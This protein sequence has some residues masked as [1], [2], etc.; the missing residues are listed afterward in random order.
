MSSETSPQGPQTW[1]E[2]YERITEE[3]RRL[4]GTVRDDASARSFVEQAVRLVKAGATATAEFYTGEFYSRF[5]QA[6][7]DE[8]NA[9]QASVERESADIKSASEAASEDINPRLQ[10]ARVSGD[11]DAEHA[12]W[13]EGDQKNAEYKA[14]GAA[15]KQRLSLCVSQL[16]AV[17][18]LGYALGLTPVFDSPE[19]MLAPAVPDEA[20]MDPNGGAGAP[21][22][23][24]GSRVVDVPDVDPAG[25]VTNWGLIL[26][27]ACAL[28][29]AGHTPFAR[30]DV[31]EWI[32]ARYPRSEHPRGSLDP[33]FQGMVRNAPSGAPN[34]AGGK[35]LHRIV[36][37]RFELVD[38]AS[39][40]GVGNEVK[41]PR[42]E[43]SGEG[44]TWPAFNRSRSSNRSPRSPSTWRCETH[45]C[46]LEGEPSDMSCPGASAL[47]AAYAEKEATMRRPTLMM[48]PR[49]YEDYVRETC[50]W[51][52]DQPTGTV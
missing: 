21:T 38:P 52:S 6:V 28:A 13:K 26:A 25:R 36:R 48:S 29:A 20:Q 4:L 41:D 2:A 18:D 27:A 30:I 10:A 46:D 11:Q 16:R 14:A 44:A 24:E 49:S 40:D 12:F 7:F 19:R 42:S 9:E 17:I 8:V 34:N 50:V 35:P 15:L 33:T 31:Y 51:R 37:G 1:K 23:D 43:A 5:R 32:W 45:N 47:A 3:L 39:C 22:T